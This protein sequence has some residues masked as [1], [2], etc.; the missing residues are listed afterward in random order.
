M[1][2]IIPFKWKSF[3]FKMSQ[4]HCYILHLLFTRYV[5]N[6]KVLLTHTLLQKYNQKPKHSPNWLQPLLKE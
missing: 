3:G 4:L 2:P 5:L 1:F 6:V